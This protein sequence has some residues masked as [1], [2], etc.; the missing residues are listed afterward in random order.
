[1]PDK[2]QRTNSGSAKSRALP[3]PPVRVLRT[4]Q[5]DAVVDSTKDA[6]LLLQNTVETLVHS[7]DQYRRL[8]TRLAVCVFELAGDGTILYVNDAAS[9]ITGYQ[10]VELEGKSWWNTFFCVNQRGQVADLNTRFQSGEISNYEIE[11][12]AKNSSPI[13]LQVSS[14]HQYGRQDRLERIVVCGVDVT[15]RRRADAALRGKDGPLRQALKMEA[16]GRLA[17]GI[18]HDFNNL[19]TVIN[20]FSELVLTRESLDSKVRHEVEQVRGSGLRAAMLTRQLLAFSR[21][22][23]LEPTVLNL[24]DVV[25]KMESLLRRLIGEDIALCSHLDPALTPVTADP[26]QLDQV[27]MNLAANARDAM[28]RGGRLLIETKNVELDEAY[29]QIHRYVRPGAYVMLAISD[30]GEGID[31]AVQSHIFEPFFTTKGQEEGTGLGLSTVYGIVKQSG[32]SI[33]VYSE[34]SHGTTFKIY[35]P[36]SAGRGKATEDVPRSLEVLKGTET[37]LLVEDDER[38]RALARVMLERFGYV[39][40]EARNGPEA[41]AMYEN[42]SGPIQLLVT[43]VVMPEMSGRD[44]AERLRGQW[45]SIKVLYMSGFTD[46]VVLLH[47]LL[48]AEH[49]FLQKPF[50]SSAL[51]S[52]VRRELDLPDRHAGETA[53][54]QQGPSIESREVQ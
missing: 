26:G 35:L 10:A 27:I 19:L 37:I 28:P 33:E 2:L 15:E 36:T 32:G 52:R 49:A 29:T 24:N 43:D 41:L 46:D 23:V 45:P 39:V 14:A 3:T 13:V 44:L 20:G 17:S 22:Q 50:S 12:K 4:G 30:N 9:H 7:Q 40:L 1:M 47:G 42:R 31:P 21:A 48:R 54:L 11:I 25:C 8:M 38:M 53:L 34:V 5:V 18:A 51:A 6:T 16:L